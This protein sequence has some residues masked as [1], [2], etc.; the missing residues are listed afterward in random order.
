MAL[1]RS[2]AKCG[3]QSS[4]CTDAFVLKGKGGSQSL[5]WPVRITYSTDERPFFYSCLSVCPLHPFPKAQSGKD[6]L[7][8]G[9]F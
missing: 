6:R 4:V 3:L 5:F 9:I 1:V 7:E 2:C 8:L